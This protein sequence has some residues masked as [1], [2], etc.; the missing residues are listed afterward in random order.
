MAK[1]IIVCDKDDCLVSF[2]EPYLEWYERKTGI[3]FTVDDIPEAGFHGM[4]AVADRIKEFIDGGGLVNLEPVKHAQ[5]AVQALSVFYEVVVVSATKPN[6]QQDSIE[7][8]RKF[9][10][11]IDTFIF[12]DDK[13]KWVNDYQASFF[14]DDRAKYFEGLN[15]QSCTP[16]LFAQP[17]N[18]IS[19]GFIRA[20]WPEILRICTD[21][22][23][24]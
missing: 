20:K 10:K 22:V 1:P 11:E 23:R 3:R 14:I 2:A 21:V 16:I 5:R 19:T 8:V 12:D 7:N 9:F 24:R 18:R 13:S 17:W 15:R 4:G 6:G